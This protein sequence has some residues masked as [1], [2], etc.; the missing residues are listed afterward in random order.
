MNIIFVISFTIGLVTAM[1]KGDFIGA[2]LCSLGIAYC[3]N[4]EDKKK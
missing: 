2:Y 1:F 4:E 3:V